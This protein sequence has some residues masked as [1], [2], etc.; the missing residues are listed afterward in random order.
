MIAKLAGHPNFGPKLGDTSFMQKLQMAQTNPHLA[1]SD[2]EIM[3]VLLGVL[4]VGNDVGDNNIIP[5]PQRSSAPPK[6]PETILAED[7]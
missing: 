7:I 4:G 5:L 6:N 2:P 3:E 1:M